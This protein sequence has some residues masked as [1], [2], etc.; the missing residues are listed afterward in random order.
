MMKCA[1]S[2][3]LLAL[4]VWTAQGEEDIRKFATKGP[5]P[6]IPK[7]NFEVLPDL[8][9]KW[10]IVH[11]ETGL[12]DGA[13]TLLPTIDA[14]IPEVKPNSTYDVLEHSDGNIAR[15]AM[16]TVGDRH[17]F[18]LTSAETFV[19]VTCFD[20]S[21][22]PVR[23]GKILENHDEISFRNG[24]VWRMRKD[25]ASVAS[26]ERMR[27]NSTIEKVHLVFMNHLDIGYTDF[28][29][30]VYNEYLH[31][32]YQ[33]AQN[34][35][36]EMR[37]AGKDL[38]RYGTHPMLLSLMYDCPKYY[39]LGN[40]YSSPLICPTKQELADFEAAVAKGDIF[41]HALPF[42][43]QPENMP[44]E[45]F[46]AGIRMA[47]KFDEQFYGKSKITLTA[48][49]RDVIYVT[50]STI[51]LFAKYGVKGLTIGSNGAD[52]PPQVPKLHV[53]KDEASGKDII[54]AYHPFGYGGYTRSDCA[55]APNG[56]ALCTSFRSDNQGPVH[57]I[58]DVNAA[59]AAV[60]KEYPGAKVFSSTFD[61][62]ILDVEP[63]KDQLPV[64]TQEVGDTW[65]YGNGADPLKFAQFREI[66][67]AWLECFQTGDERCSYE[68]PAIQNMTRWLFKLPE[69]T[70]GLPGIKGWGGGD[71]CNK[72]TF[73]PNLST[74]PYMR[75]AMS[76][77]EQ[78]R[79][80]EMAVVALEA[81]GH[82]LAPSVRSRYDALSNVAAPDLSKLRAIPDL[83]ATINLGGSS[84]AFNAANGALSSFVTN[85]YS[86]ESSFE[87]AGKDSLL[88]LLS[89]QTLNESDWKPFTFDYINGHGEAGGFCK[90]GSNNYS[91]S[92]HFFPELKAVYVDN[93]GCISGSGSPACST[94]IAELAFP[95]RAVS[96]YGA[97]STAYVTYSP[98]GDNALDIDAVL[99]GKSPTMIGESTMMT[100]RPAP[101]LKSSGAWALQKLGSLVDPEDVVDGGNQMN[102]GIWEGVTATTAGGKTLTI[103]TF[104]AANACPMTPDFEF[105][106][107]LPAGSDG[108]KSLKTGSVFG[109]GINL[110][111][112]LWNTN[113]PLFYPYFDVDLCS[114]PLDCK[115]ANMRF[116]FSLTAA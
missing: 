85:K 90:P 99:L 14:S 110:H 37:A 45:L 32:Y 16:A 46:E 97:P 13:I 76:W 39:D 65:I 109:M 17:A 49:I 43:F 88:G 40:N 34:I 75:S 98:N 86:S 72:S 56:V 95:S 60:R 18:S 105:G 93:L 111:N 6:E 54:V 64:V 73:I 24:V 5:W 36:N 50:R 59:L 100:F 22:K 52:Y 61:D 11:G 30:P 91:E 66:T 79:H 58:A 92:A 96:V 70:W 80:N 41:W 71:D 42:N 94:V 9:G 102:H 20:E 83:G 87:W 53:W 21:G 69:H 44:A 12:T 107:P 114:S 63:V 19:K 3:F 103:Q 8:T 15:C 84:V 57:E 81:A 112:N 7:D 2:L 47:R 38:Y 51:P 26:A 23:E 4:A 74:D 68:D 27:T 113:Y 82:H 77:A 29:L 89:Y 104:D 25:A 108:L 33:R 67:R 35:S 10:T 115:N 106:N 48:S 55:E 28:V 101:K 78:R 31:T 1:W 62:F 116:R